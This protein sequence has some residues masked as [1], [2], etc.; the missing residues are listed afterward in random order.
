MQFPTGSTL[1]LTLL[2]LTTSS[3]S[4]QYDDDSSYNLQ[5][6]DIYARAATADANAYDDLPYD[7]QAR[8]LY[9]RAAAAEAYDEVM[10]LVPR[11]SISECYSQCLR[12]AQQMTAGQM[13]WHQECR[14]KCNRDP[15]H[16]ASPH[17]S[18]HK[19]AVWPPEHSSGGRKGH[20]T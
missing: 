1:F 3:V 19:D 14:A 5:A 2:A 8:H 9:A 13:Q 4:A 17:P 18:V 10:R 6:R 12:D 7:L 15:N 16:N 20:R 11:A